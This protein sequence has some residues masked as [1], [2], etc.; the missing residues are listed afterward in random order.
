MFAVPTYIFVV[1]GA[2]DAPPSSRNNPEPAF[3]IV[4]PEKY[5]ELNL[6]NGFYIARLLT[7]YE[8]SPTS[9]PTT[10][11][12]IGAGVFSVFMVANPYGETLADVKFHNS[13]LPPI[14]PGAEPSIDSIVKIPAE[15]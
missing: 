3:A 8:E 14:L 7:K 4:F 15:S 10:N 13:R 12:L 1:P 2:K 9:T 11:K 5:I 6:S